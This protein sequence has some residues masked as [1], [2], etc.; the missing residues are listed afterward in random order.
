[1]ASEI[2]FFDVN[3]TITFPFCEL[4]AYGLSVSAAVLTVTQE[5]VFC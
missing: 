4:P 2:E 5:A 1:M 3:W